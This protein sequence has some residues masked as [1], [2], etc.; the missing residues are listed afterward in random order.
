VH[1]INLFTSA[2]TYRDV[3]EMLYTLD[4]KL[5]NSVIIGKDLPTPPSY[6]KNTTFISPE[7]Y[8]TDLKYWYWASKKIMDVARKSGNS[9]DEWVV[10][11]H[12]VGVSCAILKFLLRSRVKKICFLVFPTLEFFIKRGWNVDPWA[13]PLDS[14]QRYAYL[15]KFLRLSLIEIVTLRSVDG[16]LANSPAIIEWCKKI[17]KKPRYFLFP[18][19]VKPL[20][21]P[22]TRRPPLRNDEAIKVLL[23]SNM[24]P[25]KGIA[26]ALEVFS[27]FIEGGGRGT[28]SLVGQV[29]PYDVAWF[30][31]MLQKY[32]RRCDVRYIGW[33]PFDELV[34]Y[35]LESDVMLFPTY[36]EGSPRVVQEALQY[37]LPVIVSDIPGTRLI[38][39]YGVS[40][41][42]FAPGD[43]DGALSH[44]W[45]CYSE[46][47]WLIERG[48][49]GS[50]LM[51]ENF[52]AERVGTELIKAIQ[53]VTRS[54]TH[55]YI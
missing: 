40:L 35:Y 2:K 26:T 11:E 36:F 4:T 50:E 21:D 1:L 49:K 48:E 45:H 24:Q 27:R 34:K 42:F 43:I 53:Q 20:V 44:L 31:R 25:H 3:L 9:E 19:S 17:T 52:S 5:A 30:R 47:E 46:P 10:V 29:Y 37:G 55:L 32:E 6:L 18:N 7:K 39:P 23:V 16:V 28:L 51:R 14:T 8:I 22:K 38:D 33:V 54:G 12:V 41:M 13:Q 15:V